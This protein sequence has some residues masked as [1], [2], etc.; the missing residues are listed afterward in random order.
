MCDYLSPG[1]SFK[2]IEGNESPHRGIR[3]GEGV[4]KNDGEKSELK[5]TSISDMK[6][7]IDEEGGCNDENDILGKVEKPLYSVLVAD[8]S[9]PMVSALACFNG[10]FFASIDGGEHAS[11]NGDRRGG[12]SGGGTESV[13][14]NEGKTLFPPR[15]ML[16]LES[17]N[18]MVKVVKDEQN[19]LKN[20]V[21]FFV[22]LDVKIL[23]ARKFIDEWLNKVWG[24]KLGITV[25]FSR[26]I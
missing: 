13:V 25:N 1:P 17:N 10:T 16:N 6:K 7:I 9:I 12:E 24:K 8:S 18:D 26:M 22:C 23:P 20:M 5:S 11:A 19:R 4:F 15:K 21:I 2:M 14:G 3:Q